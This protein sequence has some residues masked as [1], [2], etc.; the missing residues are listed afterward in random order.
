MAAS[1]LLIDD[2]PGE[3][4]LLRQALA[5]SGYKGRLD[6]TDSSRAAMTYLNDHVPGDEP[7]LILLD[8]KL[9]G[10]RGV[11]VL[12]RLKQEA[13]F[14]QIPVVILT[15]SDDALDVHA[16]YQAGAN[17][18]LVKPGQFD[19]LVSLSLHLWKFWLEHNC[20]GR[21]AAC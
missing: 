9:Q 12:K 4:E 13:R 14:A 1:I 11:D 20:T 6:I 17:G 8:L 15:S 19:D 3:C 7:A 16:C 18:Y 21:M 2:S 5:Q 10:E